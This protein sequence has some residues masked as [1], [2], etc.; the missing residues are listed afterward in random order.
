MRAFAFLLLIA[1][2]ATASALPRVEDVQSAVSRG[3]YPA[4][5]NLVREVLVAKPENAKAHYLLAE[6]LAHEGRIAEATRQAGMAQQYDPQIRFTTPEK[7]REFQA[8]LMQS[9]GHAAPASPSS[10]SADSGG[11]FGGSGVWLLLA[12]G[13][14]VAWF[15][16]RRRS[17]ATSY[18][19]PGVYGGYGAATN[20]PSPVTPGYPPA[21]SNYPG[22][23]VGRTVAAG[24]G[25]LAAGMLAEHLIE[26]A[27]GAHRADANPLDPASGDHASTDAFRDEP[28]DFGSG[29]DWDSGG[30]SSSDG[31]GF[32]SGGGGD[33]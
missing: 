18:A 12:L 21:A 7:F 19:A 16:A 15:V 9:S 17:T 14:G 4:A 27:T 30:G 31:G 5:E 32:D 20:A 24:L 6:I 3:D 23:G 25:G 8:R 2:A 29:S 26:Q 22:S 10:R 1:V 33:W 11:S 13:L 28:I